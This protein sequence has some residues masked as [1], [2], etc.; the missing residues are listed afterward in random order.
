MKQKFKVGDLVYCPSKTNHNL[1]L[2]NSF[3]ELIS[4]VNQFYWVFMHEDIS[5]SYAQPI[6]LKTL[7][8]IVDYIDGETVTE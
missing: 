1:N 4:K 5:W 8:K 7:K 3:I 2:D 6:N